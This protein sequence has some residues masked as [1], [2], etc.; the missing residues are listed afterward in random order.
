MHRLAEV[1]LA[2]QHYE[3]QIEGYLGDSWSGWFEGLVVGHAKDAHGDLVCTI[4]SGPMDQAM[5]CGVLMRICSLG[6]SLIS[7]CRVDAIDWAD[8][9]DGI[10]ARGERK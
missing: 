10:G 9:R 1:E 3:I 2:S 5:L 6:L 4:L 7:I 8:R